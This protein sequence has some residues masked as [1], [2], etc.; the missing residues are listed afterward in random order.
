MNARQCPDDLLVAARRRSLSDLERQVLSAHV[1]HCELCR[2]GELASELLREP[3]FSG[4]GAPDAD[5]ALVERVAERA[6]ASLARGVRRTHP[7]WRRV[8]AA[9]AVFLGL[10]GVASAAAWIGRSFVAPR[11]VDKEA[12][13]DPLR[14]WTARDSKREHARASPPPAPSS[15]PIPPAKKL[16]AARPVRDSAAGVASPE[17]AASLFAEAARARHDGDLRRAVGLYGTLRSAFPDSDQARVASVS[18]ADLLLRLDEPARALRAFDAYLS[19]VRTGPMR[20]EALFGRARSLSKLGD[21]RAEQET[22]TRLSGTF[23]ARP[24]ARSLVSGWRSCREPDER[25]SW[26]P[27][28]ESPPGPDAAHDR[29]GCGAG[30]RPGRRA[31]SAGRHPPPWRSRSS[32]RRRRSRRSARSRP[33]LLSRDGVA[34]IW[35]QADRLRVEDVVEAPIGARGG[36]VV[37]WVDV[38]SGAEARI[39]FRAAAGQRFVIRR[40]SLSGGVGLP[41]AEEIAQIIHSVLRALRCGHRLGALAVGGPCRA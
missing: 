17:T 20:E 39:Y 21:E 1:A 2:A 7:G 34:L 23:P 25:C 35:R 15:R 38:S 16:V 4:A 26:R 13:P 3:S 8:A 29:R 6:S 32:G 5:R 9:V 28:F 10:G 24:M 36:P 40:V 37:V 41:A 14:R 33:N 18:M 12:V 31:T 11:A 19:D 27:R 30:A 22:W